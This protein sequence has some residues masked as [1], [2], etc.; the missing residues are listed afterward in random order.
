MALDDAQLERF[1]R[2]I[3][4]KDVG[5]EGQERI[6]AGKVLIIGAGALAPRL[7]YTLRRQALALSV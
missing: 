4:L 6:I 2:H 7:L 3:L 5:I 1:S